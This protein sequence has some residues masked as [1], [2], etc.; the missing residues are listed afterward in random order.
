MIAP[1][2]RVVAEQLFRV[3]RPGNTVGMTAWTPESVFTE[4]FKVGREWSR[5]DPDQPHLEEWGVEDNVRER[6]DGLANSMRWSAGASQWAAGSPRS[7]STFME[8]RAPMQVA[9][10]ES[11]PAD[12]YAQ[13]REGMLGVVRGWAGGDGAFS[14]DVDTAYRRPQARLTARLLL[15]FDGSGFAG[16]ATQPRQRT[17]QQVV[18]EALAKRAGEPVPLTV[19][20]R[21]DAGVHAQLSCQPPG[22]PISADP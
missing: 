17:V 3:V 7:T 13:L 8:I 19:A 14:V 18:E 22:L 11:M 20:G 15:K 12:E 5:A 16:W 9:A 2:P 10:K 6:F 4:L 1:R 21:T